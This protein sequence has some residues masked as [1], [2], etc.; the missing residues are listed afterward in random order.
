MKITTEDL[1]VY[2]PRI[3]MRRARLARGI[4]SAREL[5]EMIGIDGIRLAN[6][7]SGATRVLTAE[8]AK[9]IAG[10][11]GVDVSELFDMK[12]IRELRYAK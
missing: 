2:S 7:E 11:L 3:R 4:L 5:G 9:K 6:F 12:T 10:A 8:E 1:S